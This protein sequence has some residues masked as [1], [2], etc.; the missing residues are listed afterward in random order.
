MHPNFK[1]WLNQQQYG[2]VRGKCI[3]EDTSYDWCVKTDIPPVYDL[4]KLTWSWKEIVS[5]TVKE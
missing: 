3:N 4:P 1:Q 5:Q 2:Y